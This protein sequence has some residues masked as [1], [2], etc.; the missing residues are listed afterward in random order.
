VG[1]NVGDRNIDVKVPVGIDDGKKL[2][3]PTSATGSVDVI[4]KVKVEPHPWF[5]RDGNDISVEIPLSVP[6][7]T[8]GAKVEVPTL[9]GDVLSV[10]VPAGTQSG[11]RIRLKGQGVAGGDLF[12]VLKL[13]LQTPLDDEGR[14][15]MEE[16]AKK[17]SANVREQMP[18]WR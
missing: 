13:V 10:K 12:A 11:S 9:Q 3:V 8:L 4:L 1:I 15:L 16:F 2:R 6:E 18:W 14:R 17:Y 7:A 5:K